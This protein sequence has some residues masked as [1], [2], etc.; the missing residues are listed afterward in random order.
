MTYLSYQNKNK[1]AARG[2]RGAQLYPAVKLFS[3]RE[4]ESQFTL[5]EVV[6]YNCLKPFCISMTLTA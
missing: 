6:R 1:S 3:D 4:A 2:A 5:I